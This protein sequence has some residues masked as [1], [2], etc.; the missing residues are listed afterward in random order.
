MKHIVEDFG[1][2][3]YCLEGYLFGVYSGIFAVYLQLE[4]NRSQKD[5]HKANNI[6]F[7][8]L[9]MLYAFS[10]ATIIL[11]IV[12]RSAVANPNILRPI[13]IL[14]VTSFGCCDFLAQSILIYRCWIVW[15]RD[16][17]VVIIPSFLTFA[18]IVIWIAAGIA[19]LSIIQ[20][21][22]FALPWSHTLNVTGLAESPCP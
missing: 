16:I 2:F 13:G 22:I 14:R 21:E 18:Y 6:L 9:C 8:A 10:M 15:S 5:T 11:D 4:Y 12:P 7:Y 20:G 3:G 1:Y 19:P 17:N